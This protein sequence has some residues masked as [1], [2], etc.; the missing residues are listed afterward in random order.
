MVMDFLRQ[1][2]QAPGQELDVAQWRAKDA[3]ESSLNIRAAEAN[4]ITNNPRAICDRDIPAGADCER[5]R[6]LPAA[7]V[8]VGRSPM[9]WRG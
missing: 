5:D 2:A 6:I 9:E 1:F 3:A 8:V 7:F 4:D